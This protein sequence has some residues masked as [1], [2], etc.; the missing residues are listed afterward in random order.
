MKLWQWLLA[1]VFIGAFVVGLILS[2]VY[3]LNKETEQREINR[4]KYAITLN[5]VVLDSKEEIKYYRAQNDYT[6]CLKKEGTRVCITA[7]NTIGE[8]LMVGTKLNVKYDKLTSELIDYSFV[9]E[10]DN[11]SENA[12]SN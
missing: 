12:T 2:I 10:D 6:L 9:E 4:N 5:N 1:W 8:T 3:L 11:G 7:S